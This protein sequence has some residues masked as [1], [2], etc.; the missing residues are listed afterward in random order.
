M[1]VQCR[2]SPGIK[3]SNYFIV[4]L[5]WLNHVHRLK[6]KGF[7]KCSRFACHINGEVVSSQLPVVRSG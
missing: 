3:S 2:S 1:Q 5:E 4:C 6:R 7:W